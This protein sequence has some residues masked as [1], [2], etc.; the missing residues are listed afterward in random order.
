MLEQPDGHI[1]AL[2]CSFESED[3]LSALNNEQPSHTLKIPDMFLYHC[4]LQ[5]H[6]TFSEHIIICVCMCKLCLK[7]DGTCTETRSHLSAKQASPFK[8][9]EASVQSTIVS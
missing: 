2:Y 3:S 9:T 5:S 1:S 4:I 8:S 6:T 7:C